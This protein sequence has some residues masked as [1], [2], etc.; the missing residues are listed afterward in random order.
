METPLP[1]PFCGAAVPVAMFISVGGSLVHLANGCILD[2]FGLTADR[3]AA[4][5]RRTPADAGETKGGM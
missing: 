2:N 3:I 4:W 1:C 5:N